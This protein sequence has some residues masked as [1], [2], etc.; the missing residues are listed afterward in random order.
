MRSLKYFF[1]FLL[2]QL[3][4][5]LQ[6]QGTKS[7]I[8]HKDGKVVLVVPS[9]QIDSITFS[10][11]NIGPASEQEPN[12]LQL[13]V[14]DDCPDS[15]HPH[16]I[17][18]GLP[19]GV[20]WACCNVG[21]TNPGE[22]GNHYA[23][24]ETDAKE[25]YSPDTYTVDVPNLG[26]SIKGTNYDVAYVKWGMAW[27]IPSLADCQELVEH[28]TWIWEQYD[29]EGNY[30]IRV[31]G[32]NGNSIFLP[33]GGFPNTGGWNRVGSYG[34]YWTSTHASGSQS[35]YFRFDSSCFETTSWDGEQ[36]VGQLVRPV[37]NININNAIK[38]SSPHS[39]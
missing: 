29:N 35:Q 32:K 38:S 5:G 8:F 39:R 10:A 14:Y 27:C 20:K 13:Q 17:D 26:N 2:S 36:Y 15:H 37:N 16:L 28:C 3:F 34:T 18:L 31:K 19:S 6:A 30:G 33:A 11:N 9:N 12:S 21:A 23:W 25:F 4:L 22:Y 7:F 24:G 1:I